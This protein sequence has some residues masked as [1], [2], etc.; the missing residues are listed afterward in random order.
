MRHV[1]SRP[2]RSCVQ[3]FFFRPATGEKERD[4]AEGHHTDGVGKKGNWHEP[5]EAAHFANIVFLV[6]AVND[7]AGAKEQERF[8]KAVRD[9]VHHACRDTTYAEGD[10]YKSHLRDS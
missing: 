1:R 6:T 2:M 8:E 4:A 10:H 3:N 9:Q 5:S 7:R